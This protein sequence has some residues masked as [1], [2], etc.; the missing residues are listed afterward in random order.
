MQIYSQWISLMF[1]LLYQPWAG[2]VLFL[3]FFRLYVMDQW[4]CWSVCFIISKYVCQQSESYHSTSSPSVATMPRRISS[5]SK[6]SSSSVFWM[7][8][9]EAVHPFISRLKVRAQAQKTLWIQYH[10][11]NKR[12]CTHADKQTTKPA[13][14]IGKTRGK[15]WRLVHGELSLFDMLLF[16]NIQEQSLNCAVFYQP[17]SVQSLPCLRTN[18]GSFR[19]G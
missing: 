15:N 19:R 13:K 16:S 10:P 2:R 3:Y 9:P 14:Y 7:T 12:T 17:F 8:C 6:Q 5:I 1:Y 18:L 4:S 11:V